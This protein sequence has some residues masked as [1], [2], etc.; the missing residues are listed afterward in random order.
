MT[1][2]LQVVDEVGVQPIVDALGLSR[3]TFYRRRQGPAPVRQPMPPPRRALTSGERTEV[4]EVL[5]SPAYIDA[6]PA[7][8]YSDMLSQGK[9]LCSVR[10]MYRVLESANEVRER[11]NRARRPAY[12]RPE[13]VATGPNQVWSWDISKLRTGVPFVY[14]FLY[15]I[16]DI[17]SRY[18]VGWMIAERETSALAKRLIGETYVR[19]G[20]EPDQLILHADNGPQMVAQ[21]TVQLCAKLG[22]MRSHNRPYVS[23]DNPYS[24]SQF[25]TAKQHPAFPKKFGGL[26]HGLSW[27][28]EFFPWYN[29]SHHHSGLAYLT[30]AQVHNNTYAE[31]LV[32]R[33][34]ALDA[35][36]TRNPE[37]FVHG[38]PRIK[39]PP[40]A[41]WINPPAEEKVE[42]ILRSLGIEPAKEEVLVQ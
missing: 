14:L 29:E 15:V 34:A 28:R 23:N 40:R 7:E 31:V 3:A 32:R 17:F 19:Q 11:R 27:G 26:V 35:A 39:Y 13:L 1:A 30:P 6:A 2:A 8:V 16:L 37:R 18:V 4:L 33:Q 41:A 10:T 25:A 12:R 22:I 24:E 36:C 42:D 5:H 21:P 20:V 38:A 9:Y